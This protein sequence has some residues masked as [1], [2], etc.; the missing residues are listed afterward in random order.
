MNTHTH[1]QKTITVHCHWLDSGNNLDK[2][3]RE[4]AS[5]SCQLP[6]QPSLLTGLGDVFDHIPC[7]HCELVSHGALKV[8]EHQHLY[9]G[10]VNGAEN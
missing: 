4:D 10:T 1:T 8:Y 2:V 6:L 5:L 3:G 7:L 9:S